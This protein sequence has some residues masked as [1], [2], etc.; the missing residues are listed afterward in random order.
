MFVVNQQTSRLQRIMQL[1][2]AFVHRCLEV[3]TLFVTRH[4]PGLQSRIADALS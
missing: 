4:V 2:R 3:N 1:F